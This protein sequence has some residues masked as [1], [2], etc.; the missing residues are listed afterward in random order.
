MCAIETSR[1]VERVAGSSRA[2]FGVAAQYTLN[3]GGGRNEVFGGRCQ[4]PGQCPPVAIE[5]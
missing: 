1:V 5:A 3:W 4:R 2:R